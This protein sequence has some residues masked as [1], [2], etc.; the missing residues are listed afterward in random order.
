MIAPTVAEV[1]AAFR[2]DAADPA[3]ADDVPW[4]TGI[5]DLLER[6]H[7]ARVEAERK[8]NLANGTIANLMDNGCPYCLTSHEGTSYCTL[9]ENAIE[10]ETRKREQAERELAALRARPCPYVHSSRE[11]THYCTLPHVAERERDELRGL[12]RFGLML[13]DRS[14]D[15]AWCGDVDAVDVQ[16]YALECGLIAPRVVKEP[17]GANGCPCE[18]GDECFWETEHMTKARQRVAIVRIG[19]GEA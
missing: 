10:A 11:G 13:F 7:K 15:E 2:A 3:N 9:A 18:P 14:R 8:L 1:V 6:E 17:C 19:E 12:A 4:L 16:N 5:A